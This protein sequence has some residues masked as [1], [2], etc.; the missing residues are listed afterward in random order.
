MAEQAQAREEAAA[1][2]KLTREELLEQNV[3]LKRR[4]KE[5]HR[6]W[7]ESEESNYW[8][9]CSNETVKLLLDPVSGGISN[10]NQESLRFYGYPR[11]A[12][13]K[14]KFW[15]LSLLTEDQLRK[16]L[17]RVKKGWR[18]E[19]S[20]KHQ[21]FDG[22]IRDV[23]IKAA[24]VKYHGKMVV[25]AVIIDVSR[26][27]RSEEL[28]SS[29]VE[30]FR[31]MPDY[32]QSELTTRWQ[33]KELKLLLDNIQTQ[34][35]YLQDSETYGLVN[36]AHAEFLGRSP[37][38]IEYQSLPAVLPKD[39]ARQSIA[40]NRQVLEQKKEQKFEEWQTSFT[41]EARLLRLTKTP[42]LDDAGN[43]EFIV[44]MAEDITEQKKAEEA[45]QKLNRMLE[46]QSQQDELTGL[47]NRRC[48]DKI[49]QREWQRAKRSAQK[50][51]LVMVDIDFFKQYNDTYGHMAGDVCLK[52]V[53]DTLKQ[54]VSRSADVVCRYG[55]E[56]FLVILP[57]TD[58]SGAARVAEKIRFDIA[59]LN[60]PHEQAVHAGK[61][62]VSVGAAAM[63]SMHGLSTPPRE[64]LLEAVDSALYRAKNKG[65][66]RIACLELDAE[67]KVRNA[68]G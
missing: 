8:I 47:A 68:Y 55:G 24:P 58:C 6:S 28:L 43:V 18:K 46:I 50:I 53:A 40:Q 64:I 25:F 15:E 16:D 39:M 21:L 32:I 44:C 45:L 62:T 14:M 35:W 2:R 27:K 20:D 12:F 42:Q 51:S 59:A 57:D 49:F 7:K 31:L 61:L 63:M 48:F 1:P 41:G 11:D 29:K 34:V 37:E 3:R 38:E 60:I 54:A 22:E 56:E 67:G 17:Y 10:F 5:L 66:N 4:C 65:K 9:F 52:K 30:E 13:A 19:F 36:K 23:E 26:Q 33:S